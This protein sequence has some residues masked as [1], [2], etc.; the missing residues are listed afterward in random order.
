MNITPFHSYWMAG[1]E[2][3]D[4]LNA[5][6][7]RVD[8]INTTG[9]LQK[10]DQDY[11][12]LAA[13]NIKTVREGIR[14]SFVEKRP[15]E[16]DWTTVKYMIERGKANNIQQLW[17]ICHFGFPDDLTPLHPMFAR[18][19]TAICRAFVQFYRSLCPDGELII[20][21]INEVSFISWLGGDVRGTSPYCHN[22][23]WDVK[24]SLVRAYIEAIA[25]MREV[26]PSVK[27][28]TTEPLIQV[29]PPT[30]A[31]E[32][33]IA[34]A[35][36]Q[37]INQYQSVDILTGR[38]CP[39]LG[40]SP[41]LID[42]L[43]FNHYYNNIWVS[44][45]HQFLMWNDEPRDYR[46]KP[47]HLLM[48]EA[49]H[50]YNKPCVLTETSHPGIDRPLWINYIAQ[51]CVKMAERKLP[52]LGV[53][54]YPIVDRPDW[55]HLDNWHH[56][57]LWDAE[58]SPG[59]VPQRILAENYAQALRNGQAEVDAALTSASG[60]SAQGAPAKSLSFSTSY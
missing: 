16:Y 41:D 2:C 36:M 22:Q 14:W 13:F 39:E 47:L 50:R 35:A 6:G 5:F 37:H 32:K 48:E 54:I 17:D 15:Y 26:D 57:G 42:L 59:A 23:G 28:M 51:E 21:P 29:V 30:D 33:Q 34:D 25:A 56:S 12:D 31:D 1:Y 11:Q 53:C 19:F 46:F 7:N 44:T 4:Q 55:D 43:G 45:T 18:R 38:I 49:Y 3:T 52:M 20:T 27:I 60:T 8:L 10:I 9:H 58:P 24:Y 40:G